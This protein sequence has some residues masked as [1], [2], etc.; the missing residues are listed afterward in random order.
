MTE[1]NY[2]DAFF[3]D[4]GTGTGICVY[5]VDD[6]PGVD[7]VG[8]EINE[9]ERFWLQGK[10]IGELIGWLIDW[11]KAKISNYIA[12]N[13]PQGTKFN[14][15]GVEIVAKLAREAAEKFGLPDDLIK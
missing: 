3:A 11:Q 5:D 9:C 2:I 14:D 15:C 13:L 4:D 10:K 6:V 7:A 12:K 1:K 8:F